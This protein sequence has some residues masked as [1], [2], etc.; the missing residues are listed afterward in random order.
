MFGNP[1]PGHWVE[2][3]VELN[4]GYYEPLGVV[5]MSNLQSFEIGV[6]SLPPNFK[7]EFM[8]DEVTVH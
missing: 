2:V 5:D 7:V 3:T 8:V 1:L 6:F 4:K